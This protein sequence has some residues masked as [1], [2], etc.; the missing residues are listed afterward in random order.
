MTLSEKVAWI[1]SGM[2]RWIG[3]VFAI[4]SSIHKKVLI[5]CSEHTSLPVFN[6]LR[7]FLYAVEISIGFLDVFRSFWGFWDLFVTG[8]DQCRIGITIGKFFPPYVGINSSKKHE[9]CSGGFLDVFLRGGVSCFS[10]F[11]T[12][13]SERK[14]SS[15]KLINSFLKYWIVITLE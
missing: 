1:W 2:G 7:V 6:R 14:D 3:E 4:F 13:P 12:I 15:C 11:N 8:L 5:G 10:P 9:S